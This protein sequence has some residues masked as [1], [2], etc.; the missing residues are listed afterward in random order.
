MTA[1]SIS[2]SVICPFLYFMVRDFHVGLDIW[3]GYYAGLLLTAYW[4]ANLCTTLFW[5]H[6]KAVLLFGLFMTSLST[7]YLGFATCYHDAI[8]A[9]VLQGAC[10]GLVPISKC[11]IGEIANR[12]Q[13]IYDAQMAA[14]PRHRHLHRRHQQPTHPPPSYEESYQQQE[15]VANAMGNMNGEAKFVCSSPECG[16]DVVRESQLQ[17]REDYAAK[18]FSGLVIAVAIG[19]ACKNPSFL[20][21]LRLGH[22]GM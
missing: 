3:I 19:A 15:Y 4:G 8:C 12:Q 21:Y 10:T 14:L 22:C 20:H 18:G 16:E 9:L 5:G 11:A 6:L 1:E 17:P 13:C 7:I 2:Q